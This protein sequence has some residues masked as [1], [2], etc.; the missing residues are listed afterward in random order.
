MAVAASQSPDS[1]RDAQIVAQE[2]DMDDQGNFQAFH[3]TSN[4]I[5][6]ERAGDFVPGPEPET[7]TLSVNGQAS[8]TTYD[9]EQ[10]GFTYTA[11]E[12]GYIAEGPAIPKL[13][14]EHQ[15]AIDASIAAG[16]DAQYV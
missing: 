8:W 5:S 11:G 2:F 13:S 15:A 9:G 10:V 14:P 16:G 4:G 12:N 7:G 3:E 1:D 6:E